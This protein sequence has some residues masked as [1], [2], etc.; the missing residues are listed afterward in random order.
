MSGMPLSR[1]IVRMSVYHL[2][3]NVVPWKDDRLETLD[4]ELEASGSTSI[5]LPWK[6]FEL[7]NDG[8]HFTERGFRTFARLFS[9]RLHE[10]VGPSG[11]GVHVIA[12]STVGFREHWPH[13]LTEHLSR[14]GLVN[15]TVDAVCGS[16]FATGCESGEHFSRRLSSHAEIVVFVGGW[17]D[18]RDAR[19]SN[20]TL[21]MVARMTVL[22]FKSAC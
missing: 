6:R 13:A 11:K 20:K 16:G 19:F 14:E 22:R 10:L 15:V 5:D 12:D 2:K 7:L 8:D 3:T 17:N 18:V 9:K 1:A 21:R 4:R